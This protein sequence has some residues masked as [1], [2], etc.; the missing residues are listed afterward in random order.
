[1]MVSFA[2]QMHFSFTRPHTAVPVLLV[3]CFPTSEFKPIPHFLF[4]QIQVAGLM[5]RSLVHLYLDFEH[6]I[7]TDL[8]TFFYMQAVQFDQH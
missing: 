3:T 2:V 8:C 7:D 1:M 4:R 6:V 5:L